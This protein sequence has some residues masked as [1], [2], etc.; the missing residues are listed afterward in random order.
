MGDG[1]GPQT[2]LSPSSKRASSAEGDFMSNYQGRNAP[3]ISISTPI[4]YCVYI[5]NCN[6]IE[7][8]GVL[9]AKS[10]LEGIDDVS[11]IVSVVSHC[12]ETPGKLVTDLVMWVCAGNLAIFLNE[13]ADHG[14]FEFAVYPE[15]SPEAKALCGEMEEAV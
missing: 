14:V 3:A 12:D 9:L 1:K 5:T 11:P 15:N 4:R 6:Q 8:G 2:S 7:L 13:L 10:V